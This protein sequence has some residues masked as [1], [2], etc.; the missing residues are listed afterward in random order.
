MAL[1]ECPECGKKISDKAEFCPKCGYSSKKFE[2]DCKNKETNIKDIDQNRF[3]IKLSKK[4]IICISAMLILGVL[5]GLGIK[6]VD[7]S[8]PNV[9][10]MNVN[11]AEDLLK[12][13]GIQYTKSYAYTEKYDKDVVYSQSIKAHSIYDNTKKMVLNVSK[14]KTYTMPDLVGKNIQDVNEQI[15]DMPIEKVYQYTDNIEK[16]IIVETSVDTGGKFNDS[17]S[18]TITV[19][20]GLYQK[21]PDVKGMDIEE[22]KSTLK[23]IGL[24]YE[25]NEDYFDAE[26]GTVYKYTPDKYGDKDNTAITLIVSKGPG[27][28]V[29]IL[30][31]LPLNEAKEKLSLAGLGLNAVYTYDNLTTDPADVV[32]NQVKGQDIEG[33]VG[34]PCDVTVTVNNPAIKVTFVDFYPNYV[35]GIDTYINFENI[36]D[37]VIA[38]VTFNVKYY[39]R[40]GYPANCSIRNTSSMNLEYTGPLNP[41]ASSGKQ[42]WDAVVYNSSVAALMLKSATITFTDNTKQVLTYEGSYWYISGYYGGELHD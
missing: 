25:V 40:M 42:Y 10:S 15:K 22:A 12:E 21:V 1:I 28:E 3:K 20:S 41:G 7:S 8:V 2:N 17:S 30:T 5:I 36:S 39:D 26:Q 23:S 27:I 38:Y 32:L 16:D 11:E 19:S 34:E 33:R 4:K 31:G 18:A 37:K 24:S 14:G 35:G 29:P 6:Y 13:R 9:V